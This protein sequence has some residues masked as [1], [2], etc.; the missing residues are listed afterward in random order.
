MPL[1]V[2]PIIIAAGAALVSGLTLRGRRR[3]RLRDG[4]TRETA[5]S[6]GTKRL[7]I[8]SHRKLS[9]ARRAAADS[10]EALGAAR[11]DSLLGPMPAY[12]NAFRELAG[13][14]ADAPSGAASRPDTPSPEAEKATSLAGAAGAG[15]APGGVDAPG[16]GR[17]VF[18]PEGISADDVLRACDGS[19]AFADWLLAPAV[20]ARGLTRGALIQLGALG[21]ELLSDI[22]WYSASERVFK[23]FL[24]PTAD[25]LAGAI[26]E[27]AL[28][29]EPGH[30]PPLHDDQEGKLRESPTETL[31]GGKLPAWLG[32][33]ARAVLRA[34]RAEQGA[35]G[36]LFGR[37]RAEEAAEVMDAAAAACRAIGS[38]AD[39][40]KAA[41]ARLSAGLAGELGRLRRPAPGGFSRRPEEAGPEAAESA[42]TATLYAVT[43]ARLLE[44][45]L[46]TGTGEPE[47]RLEGALRAAETCR[48]EERGP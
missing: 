24:N 5:L 45:P 48:P 36:A 6:H 7:L 3:R 8:D 17:P 46:L 4:L 37:G 9:E 41:L 43:A 29:E 18:L 27:A 47:P 16:S 34:V 19:G 13:Q 35:S 21:P 30:V 20:P 12:S 26:P 1:P 39:R 28:E 31:L 10:L 33:S 44:T 42:G 38:L 40:A 14:A 22:V 25:W 11:R 32:L 15:P 23:G 2:L